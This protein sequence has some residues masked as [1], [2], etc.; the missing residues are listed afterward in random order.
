M[1]G[2]FFKQVWSIA[3]ATVKKF[4]QEAAFTQSASIAFYTIFSLPGIL[5]IIIRV[6]GVIFET[7]TV[8]QELVQRANVLLGY[9]ASLSIQNMIE[10]VEI[11]KGSSF[12]ILV[13]VAVLIFSA[14]TVFTIIQEVLNKIWLVKAKPKRGW[15]KYLRDRAFSFIMI[16]ILG[17][18]MA[19]AIVLDFL[20]VIFRQFIDKLL[21]LNFAYFY[22][23]IGFL[24]SFL[25][26]LLIFTL[27]F[28]ILPDAKIKWRDVSVGA[29]FTTALFTGGK[30]LIGLYLSISNFSNTYGAAGAIILIMLWINYSSMIMLMGATFTQVYTKH[31]GRIIQPSKNAVHIVLKEIEIE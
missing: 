25:I 29:F 19:L 8:K 20:V 10:Q 28:K 5:I 4:M 21:P 3:E 11:D 27:L 30:Y 9:N 23:F 26:T 2:F 18:L 31:L 1:V 13:G 14:T 7:A 15:V 12:A 22:S 6:A 17:F 16:L 24:I